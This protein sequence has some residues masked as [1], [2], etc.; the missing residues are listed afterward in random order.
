MIAATIGKMF[1]NAYNKKY[2]SNYDAQS[3]FVEIFYPLFFGKE[4]SMLF[5]GNTPLGNPSIK[6]KYSNF[7]EL[8]EYRLKL[9]MEKI[10][11][12]DADGGVAIDFPSSDY[13]SKN[14]GQV[15]NMQI[16]LEKNDI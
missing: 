1:L 4:K 13:C 10:A 2:G 3:F 16:P 14:S 6:N 8:R 9:L 5:A 11:K 15:T 12:G 7:Q